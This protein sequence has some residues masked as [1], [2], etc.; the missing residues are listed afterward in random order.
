MAESS[1]MFG[2]GDGTWQKLLDAGY[3]PKCESA[4]GIDTAL[5]KRIMC[6]TCGLEITQLN[7]E[8]KDE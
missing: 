7:R 2:L 3:C 5:P 4:L 1:L 6:G 8:P